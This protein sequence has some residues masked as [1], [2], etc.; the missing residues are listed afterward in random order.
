MKKIIALTF[1]CGFLAFCIIIAWGTQ[2]KAG[3]QGSLEK[4][5]FMPPTQIYTG[6][7]SLRIGQ[8]I[9]LS[10]LKS[11]FEEAGWRLRD[12]DQSILNQEF[13]L[14]PA[15]ICQTKI[16]T[17]LPDSTESCLVFKGKEDEGLILLSAQKILDI[18][19][20]RD[21][22][23]ISTPS[24]TVGS[25]LFAQ[26]IDG[27]AIRQ[28]HT[29]ISRF[30]TQC[31]DAILAIEDDRFLEHKGVSLRSIFRAFIRNIRAGKLS[32]GG[33]T[34]TQQLIKNKFLSS[35]KTLVRK[36]REAMMAIALEISVDKNTILESYLNI[37]Y[38][39]QDGPFEVRGFPAAAE[40]YF[41][42]E[43]S[44]LSLREC[45]SLAGTVKGAGFYGPHKEKNLDRTNIVLK[46]MLELEWIGKEAYDQAVK[47]KL[48]VRTNSKDEF[49][50]HYFINAVHE[51]ITDNDIDSSKGLKV[52]TTLSADHQKAAEKSALE[53]IKRLKNTSENPD[54]LEG[55]IVSANPKTGEVLALVG[56]SN[57]KTS[58]YNRALKNYRPIGSLMK[59]FVYLSALLQDPQLTPLSLISN[60]AYV[61]EDRGKK[62]TPLNY[63]KKAVGGE[64]FLF[65]GLMMSLNI[66][67][68]RVGMEH[69]SPANIV[70]MVEDLGGPKDRLKPYPS[71]ILG[72]F[73]FYP[74]EVL[75][76]YSTLSQMGE[77]QPIHFVKQIQDLEGASLWSLDNLKTKP[78]TQ[79]GQKTKF[80]EVIGMMKNTLFYGTARSSLAWKIKGVYAGKTGTT[81]FHKDA[82]F[83]GFSKDHV[84]IAWVGYD[85]EKG[86]RLTGAG[87]ALPLWMDY[88]RERE[89]KGYIPEDFD[90]PPQVYTEY[91]TQSDLNDLSE[92]LYFPV[93][94][95]GVELAIEQA[96]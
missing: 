6:D 30:P 69:T 18:L 78:Q 62:W 95:E 77:F 68:T 29:S 26:F 19:T 53:R 31:L 55:L 85:K 76:I 71:V 2:L 28:K 57:F 42:K 82:W 48:K 88:I 73:E 67:S 13:T 93:P 5:W 51:F 34:I 72:T 33:S 24:L 21:G 41:D 12:M 16:D 10:D 8:Q 14:L 25:T 75:Q 61:H 15:N 84:A 44:E 91:F 86:S 36:A 96:Y 17:E 56:G 32:E 79:I 39:G 74:L 80:A 4:G 59:P 20:F 60:A 52:F 83:A 27:K 58:P 50:A 70:Q 81:S 46:R 47:E 94:D 64:A 49:L 45:A 37:T 65:Q 35:E 54:M 43:I 90:W 3:I 87:S 9:H 66:P 89:K 38:M 1:I 11:L 7:L 63:N 23:I 92:N 40:F 22:L